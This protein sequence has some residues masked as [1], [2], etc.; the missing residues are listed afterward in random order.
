M[1]TSDFEESI[2]LS[3][4]V[5]DITGYLTKYGPLLAG[6]IRDQL[7]HSG[8]SEHSSAFLASDQ[9]IFWHI[10]MIFGFSKSLPM[11]PK[12]LR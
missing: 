3:G 9:R 11:I 5:N 4:E 12:Q 8:N 7:L 10:C 2:S 6:K 1:E